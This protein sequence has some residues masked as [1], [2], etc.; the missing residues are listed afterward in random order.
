MDIKYSKEAMDDALFPWEYAKNLVPAV[1]TVK[2]RINTSQ[3]EYNNQPVRTSI[4]IDKKYALIGFLGLPNHYFI[5]VDDKIW[6]P[7]FS[8]T[9]DIFLASNSVT[10]R[11]RIITSSEIC[12]YCTYHYMNALFKMDRKFNIFINNCQVI[13]GH[14]VESTIIINYHIF[15]V[16]AMATGD[17]IYLMCSISLFVV[18]IIHNFID[19]SPLNLPMRHCPHIQK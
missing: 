1:G 13:L 6:H 16:A 10:N 17:V 19:Q 14:I 2:S 5:S 9:K 8:K 4:I 7:G 15:L 3:T 11:A 18:A 12:H